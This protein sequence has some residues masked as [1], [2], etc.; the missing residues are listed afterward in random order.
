MPCVSS[1]VAIHVPSTVYVSYFVLFYLTQTNQG[2]RYDIR[3]CVAQ[4]FDLC[5]E[6][7]TL[8]IIDNSLYFRL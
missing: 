7:R 4:V 5:H 2:H 6:Y 3:Q 8:A 1:D